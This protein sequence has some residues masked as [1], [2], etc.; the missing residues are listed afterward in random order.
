MTYDF[1]KEVGG[2]VSISFSNSGTG[3]LGLAFTEAKN[4]V[5]EWSDA[6]NGNFSGQGGAL[7]TELGAGMTT[8]TIPEN[9]LR[10]GFRYL[11]AFLVTDATGRAITEDISVSLSFQ[12]T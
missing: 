8:Y 6:S 3:Q 12:P 2:I 7:Y 9:K 1:G 4:Y 10:G 11:T 5:G